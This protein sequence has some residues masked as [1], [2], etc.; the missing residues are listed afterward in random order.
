MAKMYLYN[1][2]EFPELP[3]DVD[4]AVWDFACITEYKEGE[5]NHLLITKSTYKDTDYGVCYKTNVADQNKGVFFYG[6]DTVVRRY[7][8]QNGEWVFAEQRYKDEGA[9][10]VGFYYDMPIWTN[11]TIRY[12]T[13]EEIFLEASEPTSVFTLD[14]QSWLTGF[15]L[16]LAGKPLPLDTS[17]DAVLMDNGVLYVK[18]ATGLL[19]DDILEVL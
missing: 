5:A 12:S 17:I 8:I 10:G 18:K 4:R 2:I 14:L 6:N 3:N 15:A 1:G 11:T 19:N 16:G 7:E 9:T 13:T